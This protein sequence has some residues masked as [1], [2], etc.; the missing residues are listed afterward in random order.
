M[1]AY[2][3]VSPILLRPTFRLVAGL[4]VDHLL[5]GVSDPGLREELNVQEMRL[6]GLCDM[7][8]ARNDLQLERILKKKSQEVEK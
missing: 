7:C 8:F 6:R 2:L 4:L 5:E 3:N 1:A